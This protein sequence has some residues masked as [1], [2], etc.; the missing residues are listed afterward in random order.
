MS[1]QRWASSCFL[2]SLFVFVLGALLTSASRARLWGYGANFRSEG[3]GPRKRG[4][5]L[6]KADLLCNPASSQDRQDESSHSTLSNTSEDLPSALSDL[7]VRLRRWRT[8]VP[9]PP[10]SSHM[11]RHVE[12]FLA[13]RTAHARL[14]AARFKLDRELDALH[15]NGQAPDG[16]DTPGAAIGMPPPHEADT[17]FPEPSTFLCRMLPDGFEVCEYENVCADVPSPILG[18]GLGYASQVRWG[19]TPCYTPLL[20]PLFACRPTPSTLSARTSCHRMP[21]PAQAAGRGNATTLLRR[22]RPSAERSQSL[23]V[24]ASPGLKRSV[25]AATGGV[26]GGSATSSDSTHCLTCR[27]RGAWLSP[28]M[29]GL[30]VSTRFPVAARALSLL[31]SH[32]DCFPQ[33]SLK[34]SRKRSYWVTASASFRSGGLKSLSVLPPQLRVRTPVEFLY[35]ASLAAFVIPPNE[36]LSVAHGGSFEGVVTWGERLQIRAEV[37]HT[38]APS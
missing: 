8:R 2:S 36:T 12:R 25:G 27:F 16:L 19:D 11:S 24:G 33:L 38:A 9:P 30:T 15:R 20:S 6:A 13:D 34:T 4:A 23:P 29:K 31:V 37:L 14:S 3:E 22:R 18:E 35:S 21:T 17:F 26:S 5:G 10:P 1:R 32:S 28:R 7:D